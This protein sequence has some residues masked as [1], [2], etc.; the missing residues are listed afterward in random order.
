MRLIFN[1]FEN[2]VKYLLI[3]FLLNATISQAERIKI[4]I[5]IAEKFKP[6]I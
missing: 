3:I 5:Y 4:Q 2:D 6:G 1:Y